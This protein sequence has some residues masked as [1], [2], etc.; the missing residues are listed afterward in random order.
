MCSHYEAPTP[1]RIRSAFNN[2]PDS[3]YQT[4]LWPTYTGAFVR[5]RHE[6]RDEDQSS[7]EALTGQF[8]LLPVWA[9]GKTYGRRTYN[10]R[11]ETAASLSSFRTAWSKGQKCIIPAA[12]IYEPDWRTGKAIPTRI[13]RSDGG[14]MSIAGLWD[15]W[16]SQSGETVYSFAMLTIDAGDHALMR[17]YHKGSEKR[18]VVILPNGQLDDW[19]TAPAEANME[20][21]RQYPA[22]RLTAGV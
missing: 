18:M 8:G 2:A 14:L 21:M 16:K 3:P 15:K 17:N 9:K 13:C 22:D 6:E 20:F 10:A 1:E 11:S 19:L 12:A 5:R 4:E 7:F